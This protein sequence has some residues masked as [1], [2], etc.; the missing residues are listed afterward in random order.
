MQN[1]LVY[2]SF[3]NY[4]VFDTDDNDIS[5]WK[6]IGLSPERIINP[7]ESDTNFS[8]VHKFIYKNFKG[9]FLKQKNVSFLHKNVVNL[10]ISYNLD[11]WS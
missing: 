7:Y 5:S 9:I 10:Y 6:S 4:V 1:Y 2:I 11:E 3:S 8:P